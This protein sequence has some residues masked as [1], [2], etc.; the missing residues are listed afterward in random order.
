[1]NLSGTS[2]QLHPFSSMQRVAACLN[3]GEERVITWTVAKRAVNNLAPSPQ[4]LLSFSTL[5][6]FFIPQR[7]SLLL[8]HNIPRANCTRYLELATSAWSQRRYGR[9][10]LVKM[11]LLDILGPYK[12]IIKGYYA[13]M[14]L[15]NALHSLDL[16]TSMTGLPL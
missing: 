8:M 11:H 15:I 16:V 7:S 4:L 10:S 1:L 5:Q 12:N 2:K 13:L 14:L 9:E 3:G 6:E